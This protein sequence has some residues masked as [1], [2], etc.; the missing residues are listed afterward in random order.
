MPDELLLT[1]RSPPLPYLIESDRVIFQKGGSYPKRSESGVFDLL[2]VRSGTLYIREHHREW[3]LAAGDLIMLRPDLSHESFQ[4]CTEE[5]CFDWIQFQ[6]T[7]DWEELEPKEKASLVGDHYSYLIRTSKVLHQQA[8]ADMTEVLDELHV[9]AK[10]TIED[11]FWSRQQLFLKLLHK[12]DQIWKHQHGGAPVAIAERTAAC[13]KQHYKE[14][15]SNP[16]LSKQLGLHIN[17]ITRCMLDIYDCT[18]QQ[19][20]LYYRLDQAKLLLL[21]TDWPIA[22]IAEE[23]GFKQT[24]HFSRLF[25]EHTGLPPLKYRR[26]FML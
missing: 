20:L 5:T 23:T 24:P 6:C 8:T 9:S 14:T 21:K 3:T 15:V 7:A 16:F 18:P 13:I 12:L 17:Y 19:Y 10:G 22:R 2:Y 1:F 4:P 11:A 26:R 25:A